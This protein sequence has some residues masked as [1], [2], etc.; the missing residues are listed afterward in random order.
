MLEKQQ[1][2][3]HKASLLAQIQGDRQGRREASKLLSSP[4]PG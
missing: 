1:E 3:N 2:E 4:Q